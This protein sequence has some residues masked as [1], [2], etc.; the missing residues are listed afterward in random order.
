MV[1][2]QLSSNDPAA[3]IQD[4][5][6]T[7]GDDGRCCSLVLRKAHIVR[8]FRVHIK[9]PPTAASTAHCL[10]GW[11]NGELLGA[12]D[13]EEEVMAEKGVEVERGNSACRAH[14]KLQV[15][16]PMSTIRRTNKFYGKGLTVPRQTFHHTKQGNVVAVWSRSRSR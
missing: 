7:Y 6:S 5:A 10:G 9:P 13:L 3:I 1:V 4:V 12:V 14:E 2:L 16:P 11:E 8:F 15:A